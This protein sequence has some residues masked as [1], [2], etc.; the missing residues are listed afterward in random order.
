MHAESLLRILVLHHRTVEDSGVWDDRSGGRFGFASEGQWGLAWR[1]PMTANEQASLER[2]PDTLNRG[3]LVDGM[4]Q[5]SAAVVA[6]L[7]RGGYRAAVVESSAAL[8]EL[9]RREWP[10]LLVLSDPGDGGGPQSPMRLRSAALR[11]L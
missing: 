4:L 7:A 2:L 1:S 9:T 11:D 8:E 5:A 3:I 6:I 10:G